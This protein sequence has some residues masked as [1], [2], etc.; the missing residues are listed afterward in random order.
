MV[1]LGDHMILWCNNREFIN[2]FAQN[3]VKE[4]CYA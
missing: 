2:Q 4:F 1:D 3:L